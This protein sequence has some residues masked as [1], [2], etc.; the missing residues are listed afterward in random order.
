MVLS[1]YL[2]DFLV[3]YAVFSC[4]RKFFRARHGSKPDPNQGK[5]ASKQTVDVVTGVTTVQW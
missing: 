4:L 3:F 5:A 1:F 2:R